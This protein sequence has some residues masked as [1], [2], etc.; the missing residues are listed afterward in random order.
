MKLLLSALA[1][2]SGVFLGGEMQL[3]GAGL[4]LTACSAS[5]GALFLRMHGRAYLPAI[6][7]AA[8]LFGAARGTAFDPNGAGPLAGYHGVEGLN[9]SGWVASD[10]ETTGRAVRFRFRVEE[11]GGSV[12]AEAGGDVLVTLGD[13]RALGATVEGRGVRYGDRLLL[14]GELEAPAAFGDYGAFL[15]RRGVG[16]IMSFPDAEALDGNGG[17][18]VSR[19][20]MGLR[21]S[22]ADSIERVVAEPQAAFGQA[23]FL[24]IR[25]RLPPKLVDDF[26]ASGASHLLA[27]SGLHVG[28][29]AGLS[30]TASRWLLGRR[31]GLYLIAPLALLWVYAAVA[32]MSPSVTRAAIMA[33]VYILAMAS[34]RP[35]AILPSLG[36]AAAVM[37]AVDPKVLWSVSFQLS[38]AAMAGI[39]AFAEPATALLSRSMGGPGSGPDESRL[40]QFIASGLAM[41][42][43]AT[44]ATWPLVAFYF[45]RV[46]FTGLPVTLLALPALPVVLLAHGCAAVAGLFAS[47]LA[48]PFGWVAWAA[49]AYVTGLASAAARLPASDAEVGRMAPILIWVYYAVLGSAALGGMRI[50]SLARRAAA[51]IP[52]SGWRV[53]L[54]GRAPLWL[55]APVSAAAAL[56]W[57]AALSLP[58]GRLHVTFADVGQGDAAFIVTPG[59]GADHDGRRRRPRRSGEGGG[60]ADALLGQDHRPGN[61]HAPAPRSRCRT[62]GGA[63]AVPGAARTGAPGRVRRRKLPR[64]EGCGGGGGGVGDASRCGTGHHV[65]GR[66]HS[67]GRQ[68][69]GAPDAGREQLLGGRPACARR[70]KLHAYGDMYAEAESRLLGSGLRVDSDVLKVAHHGSRTS[71]SEEFLRRVSPSAAVISVGEGNRYGHP[72]PDVLRAVGSWVPDGQTF[73]TSDRGTVEFIYDGARLRVKTE[74]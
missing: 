5:A 63:R 35:R 52:P 47:W 65:W 61:T 43:A 10:P 24:G 11:I 48:A 71:S 42:A 73:L 64:L 23:V 28:I 53:S 66:D 60:V 2:A 55:L 13:S 4:L 12:E 70:G 39:A 16:S 38:F 62:Y 72:H 6:F 49:G 9:A 68:P 15:V 26:R 69:T 7:L 29:L 19:A 41:G 18:P 20:L 33:S 31:R 45:E 1:F 17:P 44:L 25:D 56:I 21:L 30:L 3:S 27:I 40:R 32:G 8:L 51:M 58:D 14:S 74:K 59:G 50:V 37:A 46:S 22:L 67:G 57:V 36:L 34:G 54:P